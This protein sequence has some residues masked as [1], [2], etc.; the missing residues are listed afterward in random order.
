MYKKGK[1]AET[2]ENSLGRVKIVSE[3]VCEN[4]ELCLRMCVCVCA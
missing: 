3:Y 2:G 4:S 1:N